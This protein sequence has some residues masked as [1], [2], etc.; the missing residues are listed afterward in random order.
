LFSHLK[1]FDQV[2]APV[3]GPEKAGHDGQLR[4]EGRELTNFS[5]FIELQVEKHG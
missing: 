1:A 2:E 4:I 3:F 5:V